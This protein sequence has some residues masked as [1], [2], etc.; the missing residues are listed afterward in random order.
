MN[1]EATGLASELMILVTGEELDEEDC[2]STATDFSYHGYMTLGSAGDASTYTGSADLVVSAGGMDF[3][4]NI[5]TFEEVVDS[6]ACSSEPVSG[7]NTVTNGTDEAVFTFD[8][9]TDCD[10]EPTQMLS[11]NGGAQ[12]EVEGVGCATTSQRVTPLWLLG[13]LG[14]VGLRRRGWAALSR[15]WA[16]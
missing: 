8:G 12:V 1:P 6:E 9:A 7:T 15:Y 14:L 16:A 4:Y 11:F 2:S 3:G 13:L 10:E 5:Q